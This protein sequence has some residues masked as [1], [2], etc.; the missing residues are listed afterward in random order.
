[1]REFLRTHCQSRQAAIE[2]SLPRNDVADLRRKF[3]AELGFGEGYQRDYQAYEEDGIK[4]GRDLDD[5]HFYDAFHAG[6]PP[7][8]S[9]V[10][11]EEWYAGTGGN[12]ILAAKFRAFVEWGLLTGG[13]A[14]L[15]LALILRWRY[16]P[17]PLQLKEVTPPPSPG[18]GSPP[19]SSDQSR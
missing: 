5:P 17:G 10:G 8:A 13:A 3:E 4:A 2:K 7:I 6:R 16:R 9:K 1:M 11:A 19:A 15:V 12:N 18:T 14:V